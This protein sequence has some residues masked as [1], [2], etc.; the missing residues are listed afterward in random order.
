VTS[1]RKLS[2]PAART[3]DARAGSQ[4]RVSMRRSAQNAMIVSAVIEHAR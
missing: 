2:G 4:L 3:A 1:S